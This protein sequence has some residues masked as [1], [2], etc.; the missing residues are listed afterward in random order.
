MKTRIRAISMV[1]IALALSA[2]GA[3]GESEQQAVLPGD[4]EYEHV[5]D[6]KDALVAEGFPCSEWELTDLGSQVTSGDCND[7]D[8]SPV[9][10]VVT[11]FDSESEKEGFIRT[12]KGFSD[13]AGFLVVGKNWVML[14]VPDAEHWAEKLG[15]KADVWW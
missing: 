15:A 12:Y 4:T 3:Q 13:S 6:L 8:L 10:V 5:E 9:T 14:N 11:V 2:C 1:A 7:D